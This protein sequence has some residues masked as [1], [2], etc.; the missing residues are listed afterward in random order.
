MLLRHAGDGKIVPQLYDTAA[1][2]AS[3]D[4]QVFFA[5][6]ETEPEVLLSGDFAAADVAAKKLVV[7]KLLD[8]EETELHSNR[9][10]TKPL[11]ELA[12][13]ELHDQLLPYITSTALS[14]STRELAIEIAV[15]C[16][17]SSLQREILAVA[18]TQEA[19]SM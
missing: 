4:Q 9:V 13:P 17:V 5:I 12:H 19:I 14:S 2:L 1:W 18:L 8:R 3:L 15:A 6:A 16:S 11:Y 10:S 7:K